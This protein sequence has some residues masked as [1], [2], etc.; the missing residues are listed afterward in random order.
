MNDQAQLWVGID[1]GK[2][3][4]IVVLDQDGRYIARTEMLKI[5]AGTRR[6][7]VS[8]ALL[9]SWWERDV[10][11]KCLHLQLERLSLSCTFAI[12]R[13]ASMPTDGVKSAFSF[14]ASRQVCFDMADAL[15]ARTTE[16]PPRDWQKAFLQG[17]PRG[18]REQIKASAALVAAQRYPELHQALSLKK[19]WGFADAAL[20]ADTARLQEKL[21]C[22]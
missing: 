13:V 15:K 1:P 8:L 4:A 16:V 6:E 20:I 22:E 17:H 18:K 9:L 14:G 21:R 3:G 5:G 11:P 2:T 12:E 19:N 7:R 10:V